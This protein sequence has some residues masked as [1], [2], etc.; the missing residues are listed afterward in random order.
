MVLLQL[1]HHKRCGRSLK[2]LESGDCLGQVEPRRRN[3][4]PPRV[5]TELLITNSQR[6]TDKHTIYN[7]HIRAEYSISL[8]VVN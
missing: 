7:K 6:T 8:V 3:A 4:I 1:T 5:Y 2:G